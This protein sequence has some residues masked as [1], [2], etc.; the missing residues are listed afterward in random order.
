MKSTYRLIVAI[1]ATALAILANAG[2]LDGLSNARASDGLRD[3]LDQGA[4]EAVR[5][6]GRS[7]GFLG[8]AEIRIPLPPSL[9][10]ARSALKMMGMQRQADELV[11]SMNRA[12][13]EAVPAA[14]EMLVAAIR[15]MS[16][17]DA[18]AILTGGDDAATRY[19]REKTADAL[20]QRF[21]PVVKSVTDR[22][23]LAEK[24]NAL[25]GHGRSLGVMK[26]Q[27]A[28]IEGY[29]T[30]KALDGLYH[31]IAVQEKALRRNPA[32]AAGEAA[33]SVFSALR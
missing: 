13:E 7:D 25:A 8:N 27:D 5:A 19:F 31:T 24:Y 17:A 9:E 32:A 22:A 11:T 15:D 6:L 2:P 1:G 30:R 16:L 18:K 23:G 29:V 28:T 20:G 21:L 33:R 14:M 12:A 3:A 4:R 10:K 26:E